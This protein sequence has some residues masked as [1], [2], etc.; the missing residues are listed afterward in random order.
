MHL[1]HHLSHSHPPG[2][3][4]WHLFS[5]DSPLQPCIAFSTK[6]LFLAPFKDVHQPDELLLSACWKN[7]FF[8]FSISRLLLEMLLFPCSLPHMCSLPRNWVSVFER[9]WTN[10]NVEMLKLWRLTKRVC[11]V[12]VYWCCLWPADGLHY[13]TCWGQTKIF[14]ILFENGCE[15]HPLRPPFM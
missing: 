1:F 13:V 3:Q 2:I 12:V 8:F 15:N 11:T 4:K 6:L 9:I 5:P 14:P 7:T 10:K